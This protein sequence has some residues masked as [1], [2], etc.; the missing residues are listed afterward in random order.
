M[1]SVK[2]IIEATRRDGGGS[3][4]VCVSVSRRNIISY[5]LVVVVVRLNHTKQSPSLPLFHRSAGACV[6]SWYRRI[7]NTSQRRHGDLRWFTAGGFICQIDS[8]VSL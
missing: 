1:T 4:D 8:Q 5:N 6:D 7:N 3:S 2:R